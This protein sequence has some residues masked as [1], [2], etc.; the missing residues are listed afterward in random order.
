MCGMCLACNW[1]HSQSIRQLT[2]K[3][4]F[5]EHVTA[6]YI[7]YIALR[8]FDHDTYLFAYLINILS[9]EIVAVFHRPVQN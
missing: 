1:I 8:A 6:L 3:C 9:D 5:L 7:Y 4:L 2:I